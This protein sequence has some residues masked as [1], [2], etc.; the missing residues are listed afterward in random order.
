MR[1]YEPIPDVNGMLY[2]VLQRPIRHPLRGDL[3]TICRRGADRLQHP[4]PGVG[5]VQSDALRRSAGIRH[6]TDGIR[7]L[8]FC[9]V[10]PQLM[11]Y[12]L[13]R[14]LPLLA[15]LQ[16]LRLYDEAGLFVSICVLIS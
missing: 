5:S 1:P 15:A 12:D 16:S 2:D 4:R 11:Y 9:R 3:R 8:G 7:L 14:A 13:F 10:Y 6:E